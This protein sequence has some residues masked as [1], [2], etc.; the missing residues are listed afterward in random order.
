MQRA[1]TG[2]FQSLCVC[3]CD[4]DRALSCDRIPYAAIC[5]ARDEPTGST[6]LREGCLGKVQGDD[7]IILFSQVRRQASV[8]NSGAPPIVPSL[9][10][11]AAWFT[12]A[13]FILHSLCSLFS[14]FWIYW[15]IHRRCFTRVRRPLDILPRYRTPHTS[16]IPRVL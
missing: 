6:R 15:P 14:L 1:L 16:A 7:G 5:G 4:C 8:D 10:S 9:S 12:L 2:M 3:C 13:V 11:S